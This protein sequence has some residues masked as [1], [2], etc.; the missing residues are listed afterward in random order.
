M[1]IK[2]FNYTK[3]NG[4]QTKRV[5]MPLITR[6]SYED[7]IDFSHLTKDEAREVMDIQMQYEIAMAPYKKKAFRRFSVDGMEIL[8]E[9]KFDME[10][11]Y[12]ETLK[13][14]TEELLEK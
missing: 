12:D 9:E 5:V 13:K 4:E 7:T 1:K 14:V 10:K 11:K 8:R 2:E 3:K 6:E